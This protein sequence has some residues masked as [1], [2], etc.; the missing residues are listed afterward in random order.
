MREKK[1][2]DSCN[3]FKLL[4]LIFIKVHVFRLS[5]FVMLLG[6]TDLLAQNGL[7]SPGANQSSELVELL[8]S[9]LLEI[10]NQNGVNSKKITNGVFKHKGALLY[11]NL[12]IQNETSNMI[13]AFGNVK[14]VQGDTITVTGDTLYYFGNTRLAIVSGKKTVLKDKKRTL[15]TR[16]I[17]YDMANGIANYKLPGRTVDEEN[18]LTS[19]EGF[20]NTRTKEFTYYK[21]VKLV[22]KKYTLTTDTLLYNSITKWSDFQGK[23]KIINKDGTVFGTKGRYNTESTQS[24]FHTRTTVDNDTYTLTADSLTV[25]GR[26]NNGKGKGNVV[27][28]AKKDKTILNGDEGYYWKSEGFSKIFGHAYV[29]N[30]ISDDTL[31]IR[32][33]T[34]YSFE[35]KKDST[36]KLIG[37]KNVFIYK[38][39]FQGKCDSISYNTA[40]SIIKFFRKPILWSDQHY[41]M[42]ADSITAFLVNNAMNRMLLKGKAFVI[43]E[44]TLVKQFNQVKGRVINA[45][46]GEKSKL[47]QVLVDGNGES[48]YYAIDDKEKMVGLNRVEC[49]K[50]NLIFVNSRVNRISFI[51]KPDGRL[52]PPKQIKPLERQ[53]DGF[54]WQ[55]TSKPTKSKTTWLEL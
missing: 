42:E 17:E 2:R 32:A 13:E 5:F 49:G 35:N 25:D 8:K 12:A 11:S 16:K 48:V 22:N 50:M 54:N 27:I 10:I 52:I 39:D 37:N 53:L 26:S 24:S 36:R 46:F 7:P 33:D 19:K 15:T 51:G 14:I 20:Y 3:P 34:L 43:T 29:R 9:D 55:I 23:T 6:S 30:V 31:Y 38:S 4:G 40:D 18:V 28:L 44:D 1:N 45:Y 21:N 41:Q 47:K